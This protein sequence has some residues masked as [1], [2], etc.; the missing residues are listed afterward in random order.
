M[1]V[2]IITTNNEVA[3]H[4][5]IAANDYNEAGRIFND[6]YCH[7]TNNPMK[8]WNCNISLSDVLQTNVITPQLLLVCIN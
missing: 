8:D 2:Y 4:A 1:N 7:A 3:G 6:K 5:I